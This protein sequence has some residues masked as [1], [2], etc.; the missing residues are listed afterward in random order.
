MEL[1]WLKYFVETAVSGS[2]TKAA[3][4]LYVSQ[5][6][7]SKT[8]GRLEKELGVPLFDRNGRGM[9]LNDCGK[10]YLESVITALQELENGK[11]KILDEVNQA[12]KIV[13]ITMGIYNP[14]C[15]DLI[16]GYRKE[17]PDIQ[18]IING[19]DMPVERSGNLDLAIAMAP[20]EDERYEACW[21]YDE[22]LV[23]VVP[24]HLEIARRESIDLIECEK[25]KFVLPG[26]T[27]GFPKG[28]YD[29]HTLIESLCIAS[30]FVPNEI[31]TTN[32]IETTT[33]T[34][35]SYDAVTLMPLDFYKNRYSHN[36]DFVRISSPQCVRKVY[37][38]WEKDKY[39]SRSTEQVKDFLCSKLIKA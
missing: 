13:R 24:R 33:G 6:V 32:N 35:L 2:M 23:L 36:F 25:Y 1:S 27:E 11:Q 26:R 3:D 37:L 18:L 5:P 21:L 14:F 19:N 39:M 20:F 31:L 17:H 38:L 12:D 7:L 10:I 30:G 4:N 15:V 16:V 28:Y 29:L 22:E 8:I 34:M 9:Q